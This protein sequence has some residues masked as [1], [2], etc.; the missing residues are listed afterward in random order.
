MDALPSSETKM[1]DKEKNIKLSKDIKLPLDN[2]PRFY[3]IDNIKGILIF[4]V[5]FAHFLLRYSQENQ[6]SFSYKIVNYIYS[7][8]MPSFIFIS[9]FLSKSD[10]SRNCK[11]ITRLFLIYIIFN[12]SQGFILYKYNNLEIS[13]MFPNH[14]YWYLLCL[15]YWRV[16]IKFLSNQ[17]FSI[18]LSFIV[19]IIIGF[20]EQI[21]SV[22]SIKR[23]FTFFPYFLIGYK[24]SKNYFE[25][26]IRLRKKFYFISLLL[27]F[28]F[29][30]IS[31]KIFPFVDI[32]HSMMFNIY[33]NY[34]ND[35][36]IRI[37]LF[38]F[39]FLMILFNLLLLPNTKVFL[40]TKFGKNSLF[41]Y[42]FHRIFSI[43]IIN[44]RFEYYC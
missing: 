43:I 32:N 21:S 23:T 38:I 1:F 22:F 44:F 36:K 35:I 6:K 2:K 33:K 16:S 12:F 11:S 13:F 5:V 26:L 41:I 37:S 30:Y 8:H 14:S 39:S 15:I 4:T 27:F 19:S 17:Y 7:F 20:S 10:N 24:F 40:I 25:K 31:L 42:L 29:I 9:G 34:K 18:I 28:I 3:I